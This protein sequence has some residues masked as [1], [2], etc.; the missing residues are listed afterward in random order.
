MVLGLFN[1][2]RL[3]AIARFAPIRDTGIADI[4][5]VVRKGERGLGFSTPL[6]SEIIKLALKEGFE[7]KY[8]V[9]ES[10]GASIAIA[11]RL[12]FKPLSHILAW[13]VGLAF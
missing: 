3:A 1:Q 11:H 13:E 7:P 8:R 6:V 12:G 4:T 10:N 2:G 9:D 5:V